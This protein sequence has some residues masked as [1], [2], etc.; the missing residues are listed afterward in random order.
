MKCALIA[1]RLLD[2]FSEIASGAVCIWL[3]LQSVARQKG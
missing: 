2:H 3:F 1:L